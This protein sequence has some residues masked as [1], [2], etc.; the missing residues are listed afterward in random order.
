MKMDF[1]QTGKVWKE[2]GIR[3]GYADSFPWE[4]EEDAI[5]FRLQPFNLTFAELKKMPAGYVYHRWT[6][7]KYE[8]EGFRTPSGKLKSTR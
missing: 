8:G 6:G 3:M 4:T 2:I 1:L 7:R 5:D